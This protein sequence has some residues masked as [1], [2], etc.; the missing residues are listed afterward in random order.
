MSTELTAAEQAEI[1]RVACLEAVKPWL[2]DAE[3]EAQFGIGRKTL[4]QWREMGLRFS[5]PTP[6]TRLYKR[7]D[8]DRF[9]SR[10]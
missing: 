4:T 3:M 2:T 5:Q 8:V 9:L 7:D 10:Y 6:R 1:Y